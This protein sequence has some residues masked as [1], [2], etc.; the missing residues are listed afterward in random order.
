MKQSSNRPGLMPTESQPTV[1]GTA[2]TTYQRLIDEQTKLT[3]REWIDWTTDSLTHN[4]WTKLL[5][6]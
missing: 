5:T 4:K 1:T 6:E 2:Q 3:T